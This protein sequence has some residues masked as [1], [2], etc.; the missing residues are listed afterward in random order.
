MGNGI[1]IGTSSNIYPIYGEKIGFE[2]HRFVYQTR[3]QSLLGLHP[4]DHGWERF[5]QD[6]CGCLPDGAHIEP[7]AEGAWM[8]KFGGRYYL[9]YAAPGT[10]YNAYANGTYVAS[11]PLGPFTYAPYNPVAYKPGGFVQ[12]TG[13]GS[14]FVDRYG[15]WWNTGTPWIGNNWKFERRI[16]MLPLKFE[17]DG[18]MWASAR[19]ADFPQWMPTRKIDDPDSLFTGWMLLSYRKRASASSTLGDFSAARVTD[20]NPRT[21]W[22]AAENKPG[23]TLEVDLGKIDTVR[24]VQVNFADYKSGRFS[25]APDI[26]TEFTLEASSDGEH[27]HEIARTEPPRRDRPNAYFELPSPARARASSATSTGMSERQTSRSA[28]FACSAM[29]GAHRRGSPGS[30]RGH[31]MATSVMR[32][33]AG[34]RCREQSATT[35]G[36]ESG[37]TGSR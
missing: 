11:S 18:Q 16:D 5:G 7:Y 12:G 15:N 31:A 14:T 23:E 28:T 22:V 37:Q 8:T 13:H 17:A 34:Q 36:S 32:Q 6:H 4:Q 20:E 3:P 21:F 2:D 1:F 24:A 30:L 10:E 9:Q 35:S 29:P 25:D 26:Y 27:W 33:S 19:F